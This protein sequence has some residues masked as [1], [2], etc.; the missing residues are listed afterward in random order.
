VTFSGVVATLTKSDFFWRCCHSQKKVTFSGVVATLKKSDFFT[1]LPSYLK[2]VTFVGGG[3]NL[4]KSDFFMVLPSGLKK[5][6]FFEGDH[7][8]KKCFFCCC[9]RALKKVFF[10]GWSQRQIVFFGVGN[11]PKQSHFFLG[12]TAEKRLKQFWYIYRLACVGLPARGKLDLPNA[13]SLSPS[14]IS[15]P[16]STA[17]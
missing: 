8:L 12:P 3:N 13:R 9:R 2:K 7:S 15:G 11:S 6:F 10:G 4:K 16:T 14:K 5:V 17:K 1:L